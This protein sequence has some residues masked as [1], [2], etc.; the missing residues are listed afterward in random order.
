MIRVQNLNKTFFSRKGQGGLFGFLKPKTVK[1]FQAVHNLNFQIEKGEFVAFLGPN[2]AGKTTTLKMLTGILY[3]TS[4]EIDVFGY[5]PFQKKKQF[6][7]MISFVMAQKTQLF[8]ELPIKD[9]FDFFA[10]I[11]E[12]DKQKYRK[13]LDELIDRFE[14]RDKLGTVGRRLSLGQRMKCE[15]ICSFLYNPKVIFLDEPTIG[16]DVN[17]AQ[18]VRNFLKET[19][20]SLG[21]TIILTTHNMQDVEEL[22]ERTIVINKGEKIHDGKTDDLKKMF[23]DDRIVEFILD[24]NSRAIPDK[25]MHQIRNS[26]GEVIEKNLSKLV[27]KSDRHT[28]TALI[29]IVL[30]NAQVSEIN[31]HEDDL[32]DVIARIYK[33]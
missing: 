33:Q 4:G 15:L 10:E 20:K 12:V 5:N 3:P 31:F 23:G 29:N 1:E 8:L 22:C 9:T 28:S 24:T 14:L 18:E 13:L 17:S 32:S 30:G 21:T 11:Y 7:K 27:I 26:G 25:I 16:L 6:K 19:N 2:G